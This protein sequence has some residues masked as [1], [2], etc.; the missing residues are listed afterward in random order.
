MNKKEILVFSGILVLVLVF[1]FGVI[2][3]FCGVEN[4]KIYIVDS[5]K[6][7][8]KNEK[9]IDKEE[10]PKI[11]I[12]TST[13]KQIT[14]NWKTYQND[15]LGISFSYPKDYQVK[16]KREMELDDGKR[17]NIKVLTD[18]RS[19][20][21]TLSATSPDFKVGVEEGC[22]YNYSAST[23]NID[24]SIEKIEQEL[25]TL[26]PVNT[27]IVNNSIMKGV[28]F[29]SIKEYISFSAQNSLLI[30][31]EKAPFTN[32]LV[33][34]P[35]IVTSELINLNNKENIKTNFSLLVDKDNYILEEETRHLLDIY[36]IIVDS[37]KF[38]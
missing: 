25:R 31:I 13:K 29:V 4:K 20:L 11:K 3:V 35:I 12:S 34:G 26:N 28:K 36:N 2:F 10:Q 33:T 24:V 17:L 21:L 22:C 16:V 14:E 5:A 37:L 6:V 7:S 38:Y 1:L 8:E 19:D 18:T 27:E 9:L 30:P 32:I 23:L 15:E